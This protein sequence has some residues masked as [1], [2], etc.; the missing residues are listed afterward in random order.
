MVALSVGFMRFK[1]I[2]DDL[3]LPANDIAGDLLFAGLL[4]QQFDKYSRL[5]LMSWL[6]F[7]GYALTLGVPASTHTT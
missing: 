2:V 1:N 4:Y 6:L 7:R 5:Q 3:I